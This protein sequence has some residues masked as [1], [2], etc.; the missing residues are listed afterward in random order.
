MSVKIL[1][2]FDIDIG[3]DRQ[4]KAFPDAEMEEL[5]ASI[6]T[7]KGLMCPILVRPMDN[8]RYRLVAGER[9][10][11][12][13][14]AM[15][16][17]YQFGEQHIPSLHIPAV[18]KNFSTDQEEMEA[19]LHENIVRL[20]LT[21]QEKAMAIAKLHEL[22][23]IK[24][25]LH[26]VGMTARLVE[27]TTITGDYAR[28]STYR[29]VQASI[30]V[31]DYLN[32][33]EVA[34]AKDLKTAQK[35]VSHTLEKEQLR[36]LM[37][38]NSNRQAFNA[39][40]N[41]TKSMEKLGEVDGLELVLPPEPFSLTPESPYLALDLGPETQQPPAPT[42]LGLLLKGDMLS[43][44]KTIKDNSINVVVTDPPYGVGVDKFKGSGRS[45]LLHEYS[46]D[47][48]EEL[49]ER[50]VSE[51]DR[52]CAV[53]A[54][55]Y[56]F[57]D[58]EY[59]HKLKS[60]F[61]EGWRVRRGPLIW[62]KGHMGKLPEGSLQGYKR[63]YESILYATRGNRPCAAITRDVLDFPADR[64]KIHAAQKPVALYKHLLQ[65][66]AIPGDTVLDAFAGRGTIFLAARD[67]LIN[68]I[69]IELSDHYGMLCELAQEGKD[70]DTLPSLEELEPELDLPDM[71][72]I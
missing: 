19:E 45:G 54:H 8:D 41:L 43:E 60:L 28:P 26:N 1:S 21:W 16:K 56:I 30:L 32:L 47:N 64:V 65:M 51:L 38:L 71:E 68:P 25:P 13:I 62:S 57:C 66:S 31:K 18:V 4:R 40:Q 33:P 22:K 59:F 39:Q 50:L 11:R 49:H 36:M 72:D 70:M 35:V 6:L 52:I 61:S 23:Q 53:S 27:E 46:E 20:G 69:G 42:K 15:K 17:A 24:N 14:T 55:V 7:E 10:L 29:D 67:L 37:E 44:I 3:S 63:S 58:M 9:R 12:T 34:N 5:K 2:I 48:Y